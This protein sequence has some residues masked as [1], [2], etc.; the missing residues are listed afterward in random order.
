MN[1]Y[2]LPQSPRYAMKRGITTT[3]FNTAVQT[4]PNRITHGST[5]DRK[6]RDGDFVLVDL[7]AAFNDIAQI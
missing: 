4:G 5:T 6:V 3:S 2:E 7:G 1:E